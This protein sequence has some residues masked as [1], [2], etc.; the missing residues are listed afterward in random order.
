MGR[1]KRTAEPDFANEADL[2]AA[3]CEYVERAYN[4]NPNR[5]R[6]TSWQIYHE[7]AGFDLLLVEAATGVQIGVEAKMALN[8]KVMCQALPDRHYERGPDYRAVLVPSSKVQIGTSML[9]GLVGLKVLGV[10]NQMYGGRKPVWNAPSLP[11]EGSLYQYDEWY[12]WMPTERCSLPEYVPDVVGG[13]PSPVA[14]TAWKIQAIRLIILL[15][16]Q[17]FVTRAD[18]RALKISPTRWTAASYGYLSPD[19]ARGGYVRNDITP[20]VKGQHPVNYAEIE[21]DFDKWWPV[22]P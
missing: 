10:Y 18:M 15:D 22:K 4:K 13:K 7:T 20:D 5:R 6:K 8:N 9:A 21:A 16:R 1:L 11:D 3:F 12:P 19:K 14:L 17:G 2:V